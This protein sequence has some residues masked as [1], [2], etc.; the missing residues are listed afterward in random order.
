MIEKAAEWISNNKTLLKDKVLFPKILEV[1]GKEKDRLM[2]FLMKQTI[3]HLTEE[4]EGKLLE[5]ITF[6]FVCNE[7]FITFNRQMLEHHISV[8]SEVMSLKDIQSIIHIF[9]PIKAITFHF[10]SES[11]SCIVS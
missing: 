6:M 1:T 9:I 5:N 11:K 4:E 7:D 10:Y 2:Y 8:A 3:A